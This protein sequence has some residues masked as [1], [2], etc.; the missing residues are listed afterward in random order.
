LTITD[1]AP[2]DASVA[3]PRTAGA[4]QLNARILY[5]KPDRRHTAYETVARDTKARA[6]ALRRAGLT[7]DLVGCTNAAQLLAALRVRADVVMLT[8]HS[9]WDAGRLTGLL[10][11]DVRT[12]A[13]LIDAKAVVLDSC[14][15]AT[16]PTQAASLS[17]RPT[18][19]IACEEPS[20]L[21]KCVVVNR[22]VFG[23]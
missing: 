11:N 5:W 2:H 18:P 16:R 10:G 1:C 14:W 20:E 6:T 7:I 15:M 3:G 13:G 12:M 9:E 4:S 23:G 17:T 19:T 21:R 22:L 8:G